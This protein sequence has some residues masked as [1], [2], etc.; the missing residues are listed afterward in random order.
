MRLIIKFDT[1][2]VVFGSIIARINPSVEFQTDS[3]LRG[4]DSEV[5]RNFIHHFSQIA[6]F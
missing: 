3:A 2:S 5:T 6:V 1:M 4:H